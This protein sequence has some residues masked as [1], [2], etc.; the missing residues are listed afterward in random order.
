MCGECLICFSLLK[1]ESVGGSCSELCPVDLNT[2]KDR[3]SSVSGQCLITHMILKKG[4]FLYDRRQSQ[5]PDYCSD[6]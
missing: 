4:F 6:K 5:K 2:S 1:V 3:D